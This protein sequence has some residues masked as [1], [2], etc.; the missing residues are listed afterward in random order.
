MV[1]YDL[2]G[3]SL[4]RSS[5]FDSSNNVTYGAFTFVE[6]GNINNNKG[7]ILTKDATSLNNVT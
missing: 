4:V 5:D 3:T 2:S 6:L 1:I 7:F